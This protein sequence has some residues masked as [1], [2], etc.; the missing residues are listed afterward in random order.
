M[1]LKNLR[2]DKGT[3]N[4]RDITFHKGLNLIVDET[5]TKN[6][7]ESGNNVGK[8]TVLRL[9]DFCLA[10]NGE[11]IYRDTEFRDKKNTQIEDFLKKNNIIIALTI[12][13]DLENAESEEIVIRKN[14]LK[15]K[16]K[17]QEIN[18]ESITNDKDFSKKLKLIIFNSKQEKPSF[19]QIISKNIRD[20]KGKLFNAV[21]IL[22]PSATQD[23]YEALYLFWLGIDLESSDK[24]QKLLAHKKIEEDLQKRL[25]K[26][27]SISQ[28][29]QSLL[30]IN[31]SIDD[32]TKRK[33][34]LNLNEQY[35]A[36]ISLLNKIK[37]EINRCATKITRLELRK[38]LIAESKSDLDLEFSRA[39]AEQLKRLYEEAK[40]LIPNIQK[41][42]EDT[43]SFHNEMVSAKIKYITQELPELESE[44]ILSKKEIGSLLVQEKNLTIKL[45]R[46]GT[47]EDLQILILELNKSF[48]K[49]GSLDEQ[50]RL[51]ES[52]Q[53]QLNSIV[54]DLQNIDNSIKSQHSLIQS[55]IG[56][57][58]KY[59]SDISDRLYGEKFILSSN[60]NEKGY[61][62]NI[63]S[64]S[65]NLGTGKKKGQIAAFDFAYIQFADALGISCPHFILHDQIENIHDNQITS[66]LTEITDEI[67]CQY[68]IPV[69]SDK[70]PQDIDVGKYKV[71]SLSQ[72]NKLFKIE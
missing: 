63:S 58:N 16:L 50:K 17:I 62:L 68:I 57:F 67:N 11:N 42:F 60:N 2:I 49:K 27:S 51:W 15:N 66:L 41:T 61:E 69:L 13:R 21:K 47:V 38:D 32:L 46:S 70:L 30:V 24:K 23:E 33:N 14:F 37:S 1:F 55:R 25:G 12:K 10:G 7:T 43:L 40:I 5:T 9:I 59:F 48:E 19:R 56:D 44:L 71:L 26:E 72:N 20:E 4:I 36:E 34:D 8:T 22:H 35:E 31:K 65:G 39:D 54:E 53:K 6:K 28:I 18:G 3:S 45:T 52:S 64:L 29:E